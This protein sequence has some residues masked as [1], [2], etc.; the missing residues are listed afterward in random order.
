MTFHLNCLQLNA[1]IVHLF[2]ILILDHVELATV[3]RLYRWV[4]EVTFV[5]VFASRL[6]SGCKCIA[7]GLVAHLIHKFVF[8][9]R[10]LLW[11]DIN[12]LVFLLLNFVAHRLVAAPRMMLCKDA[13]IGA[14]EGIKDLTITNV[15][16]CRCRC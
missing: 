7:G 14:L 13:P 16:V 5:H 9:V 6:L 3:D 11:L 1:S 2:L 15:D 12:V 4:K 10:D 8:L